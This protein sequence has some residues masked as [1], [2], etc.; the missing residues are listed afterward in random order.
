MKVGIDIGSTTIKFVVMDDEKKIIHK[1]YSRHF[2]EISA[3]LTNTL[4]TLKNIVGDAKFKIALAGSAGMGIAKK[5]SLPFVQEV[6]ACQTAVEEFIPQ[7]DTVIELGGEDAKIIYLGK[8]PEVRMNGVC[9]GG[10]GSFI[11][12]MAS[13]LS[14][15]ALGL[16]SLAE[17]GKQ[18]YTIASRCG[19]FAKTDIQALMND[20]V[21][22]SDIALSIFQ[23]VV[24]QTIGN[25]AQGRP[26]NG[27]VALRT[28]IFLLQQVPHSVTK[29]KI[30]Q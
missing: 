11:D 2:S 30:F 29:Q 13:L 4:T 10:T 7:T 21:K 22:K 18:I 5:I 15:D 24:N 26:I 28:E 12:H 27:V 6:I 17:K 9:A 16:N 8:A 3:A 1:E 23:A 19:V 14:T 20:G 25:L